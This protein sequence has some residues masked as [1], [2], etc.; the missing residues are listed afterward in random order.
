[1]I[2]CNRVSTTGKISTDSKEFKDAEKYVSEKIDSLMKNKGSKSVDYF[3]KKLGK[4]MWDK[5]GMSRNEK[6]L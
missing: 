2:K 1:M 5:C 4:I 6:D 3:H